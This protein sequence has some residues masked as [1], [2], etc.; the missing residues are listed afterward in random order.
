MKSDLAISTLT[1]SRLMGSG[2]RRATPKLTNSGLL[3][4]NLGFGAP[5][6]TAPEWAWCSQAWKGRL[7]C[8]EMQAVRRWVPRASPSAGIP[9]ASTTRLSSRS[10]STLAVPSA[11]AAMW[12][13]GARPTRKPR[14]AISC[15]S[16]LGSCS[17]VSK[18]VPLFLQEEAPRESA[19]RGGKGKR[20]QGF[21]YVPNSVP[22][23]LAPADDESC[24]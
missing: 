8:E 1:G 12:C 11:A 10:S 23:F 16:S 13:T 2:H 7:T 4:S 3:V 24:R 20:Q 5:G 15:R 17:N 22:L 6:I 21:S 9:T 14:A 19:T 18:S